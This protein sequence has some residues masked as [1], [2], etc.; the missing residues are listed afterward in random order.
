M[1]WFFISESRIDETGL[2]SL[3]FYCHTL[4]SAVEV[5]IILLFSWTFLFSM[6]LSPPPP[7]FFLF[8]CFVFLFYPFFVLSVHFVNASPLKLN[9]YSSPS[10][11]VVCSA[12]F[13]AS[14]FSPNLE[15]L[16]KGTQISMCIYIRQTHACTCAHLGQYF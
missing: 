8:V 9:E 15:R 3:S 7:F 2:V 10:K 14:I 6:F 5:L 16:S 12:I 11:G 13:L 1:Q 4:S